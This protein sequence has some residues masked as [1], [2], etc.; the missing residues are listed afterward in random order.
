VRGPQKKRYTD[1]LACCM[2][3]DL[4]LQDARSW[5]SSPSSVWGSNALGPGVPDSARCPHGRVFVL[6]H[7]PAYYARNSLNERLDIRIR[8][9]HETGAVRMAISNPQNWE[10]GWDEPG[11]CGEPVPLR[12]CPAKVTS[13]PGW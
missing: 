10:W 2:A 8:S 3:A 1:R 7:Q 5:P 11:P 6:G 13:A 9:L 4:G 12:R